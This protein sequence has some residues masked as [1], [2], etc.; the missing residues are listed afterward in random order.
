MRVLFQSRVDARE[1]GGGDVVQMVETA[2]ELRSRGIDVTV[3]LDLTESPES[4]DLVHLFNIDW[5]C[6]PPVLAARANRAGVPVVLSAIHHSYDEYELYEAEC[7]FGLAKIGNRLIRKSEHRDVARNA[8]KAVLQPA[9]RRF[10]GRQLLGSFRHRQRRV[11]ESAARV[12]VQT[13]SEAVDILT[14][15]NVEQLQFEKVTNGVG[16]IFFQTS[17]GSR[18]F[19]DRTVILCAGRIEPRKNQVKIIE[20]FAGLETTAHGDLELVF[21]GRVNPHHPTYENTFKELVETTDNVRYLGAVTQGEAAQMLA[22]ARIA[23]SASWFETTGLVS[24]EAVAAGCP[25]IVATERRTGEYLGNDAVYCDPASVQSIRRAIE[26]AAS[27]PTVSRDLRERTKTQFRWAIAA[28][29]TAA[30]YDI[31]LG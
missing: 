23:L 27:R 21:I 28:E 6:E 29:Q 31:V 14:D 24:I 4:Y 26:R 3:D 19:R 1:N 9:K 22:E 7:Q 12:L 20:A 5:L 30:I 13:D 18:S 25:S 16:D 15:F 11:L 2:S 8:V 10:F 17:P